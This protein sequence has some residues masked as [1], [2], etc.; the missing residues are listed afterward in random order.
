M[1]SESTG[2]PPGRQRITSPPVG[3]GPARHHPGA[4]ARRHDKPGQP[5]AL[6]DRAALPRPASAPAGASRHDRTDQAAPTHARP[7]SG[8]GPEPDL[9]D[10]IVQRLFAVG[11]AMQITQ[12]RSTDH[13][14][15]A[16]RITAHLDDLQGIIKQI[17]NAA[18]NPHTA[19][20]SDQPP[21]GGEWQNNGGDI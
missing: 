20:P 1:T 2:S 14:E 4:A 15:L 3:F 21:D 11:L 8:P 19:L 16:D 10:D 18:P 5:L 12:R 9:C 13:P 17:R 6:R 7:D